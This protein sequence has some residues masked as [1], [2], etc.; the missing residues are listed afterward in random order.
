MRRKYKLILSII[1]CLIAILF[2]V[3]YI[4]KRNM[5]SDIKM[6]DGD[7]IYTS[8]TRIKEKVK[9]TYNAD[10]NITLLDDNVEV[11]YLD[12]K[13]IDS[14][15]MIEKNSRYYCNINAISPQTLLNK[16]ILLDIE[17]ELV[18]K[19]NKEYKLRSGIFSYEGNKYIAIND[20]EFILNTISYWDNN[21]KKIFLYG[22]KESKSTEKLN[23]GKVALIRLEDIAAGG[24]LYEDINMFKM[25]ILGKY[26]NN[27]NIK[28]NVAWIPR[29]IDKENGVDN[30]FINN[31]SFKNSSFIS[32]LDSWI[33]DNALIGLH[34]YTHQA[35]NSVSIEGDELS[36]K[37]NN[38]DQQA[39][40]VIENAIY[41]AEYLNIPVGFFESPHY[42]AT[43]R[44]HKIIEEYFKI[45]FEPYS[46]YWNKNPLISFDKEAIYVPAP[47]RTIKGVESEKLIERI[48]KN[49]NRKD[50]ITSFFYHPS[51]EYDYIDFL[52]EDNK[53]VK[54][55][56]ED[57]SP[58]KNIIDEL[59]KTNHVT[60]TVDQLY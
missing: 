23:N 7:V 60:I 47:L 51:K 37:H 58:I 43:L 57:D 33:Y 10:A 48:R 20:L 5:L 16:D 52:L 19:D 39:R 46:F 59:Y 3:V 38:E 36:I 25:K 12:N 40:Q 49:A 44:Q 6:I 15:D 11:Y 35:G 32:L 56:L 28:F 24:A 42:K 30:D 1:G 31:R 55:N 2:I 26:L 45:L 9:V 34:G 18:I 22:N 13:I 8:R 50:I 53:N 27:N 4:F 29:Y 54:Y 21:S 41:T 14:K 17:N